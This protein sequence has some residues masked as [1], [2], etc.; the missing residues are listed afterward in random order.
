MLNSISD[1]FNKIISVFSTFSITDFLDIVLVAGVIYICIRIIRESRAIQLAK[2][3]IYLAVVYGVVN[4]LGMEASSY[5]FK[6]IF[7]NI[8]IILVI[9]FAPEIRNIL[10][11][12]GHG[13]TSKSIKSI[14]HPGLAVEIAEINDSI[15]AVCKACSDMSDQKIGAL[16]C[17]ENNTILGDVIFTGTEIHAKVTKELVE[18]IFFPKSPLHDGAMVIRDGKINAAGCIL[19]LTK[20]TVS[21]ALG[22]RHRAAIGLSEESD[23]IVVIVSEETGAISVARGGMLERDISDGDLRDLLREEFIPSGSSNDDSKISRLVRRV[24]K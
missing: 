23:A 5:I 16:I 13:A 15:E 2:G 8:F 11:Q 17:F 22:T 12:V 9:L 18:N 24:K 4:L 6:S 1:M 14:I 3:L 21:S 7:S 19:P 10:E 20:K